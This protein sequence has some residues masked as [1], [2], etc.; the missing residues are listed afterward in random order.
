MKKIGK[1]TGIVLATALVA[2]SVMTGC[3]DKDSSA[4]VEKGKKAVAE[5]AVPPKKKIF[6]DWDGAAELK[7]LQ[8]T[9]KVKDNISSIRSTWIVKGDSVTIITS[10]TTKAK[11]DLSVPCRIAVVESIAGGSSSSIYGYARNG[12]DIYIGLGTSGMKVGDLYLIGKDGVV[13][14]DGKVANY[15]AQKRLGEKGF[16]EAVKVNAEINGNKL[17]FEVPNRYKKGELEQHTVEIVGTAL[18]NEQAK[19]NL[20]KK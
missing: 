19:G 12:E 2:A 15:Y 17:T 9:L 1:K 18:L 7:K 5:K 4:K 20:V 16:E 14:Y 11:L 8:G 6:G 10:D 3:Q 13:A